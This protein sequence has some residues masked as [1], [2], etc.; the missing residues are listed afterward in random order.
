M[1]NLTLQRITLVQIKWLDLFR[2]CIKQ[3]RRVDK[4][5]KT[6]KKSF[7]EWVIV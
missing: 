3:K 1:Q 2:N 4:P 6:N 5:C 7:L